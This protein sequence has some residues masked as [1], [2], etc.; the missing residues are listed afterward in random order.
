MSEQLNHMLFHARERLVA[1]A[2]AH[3]RAVVARHD[4]AAAAPSVEHL[5]Q[6]QEDLILALGTVV[7]LQS[8]ITDDQRQSIEALQA[9]IAQGRHRI[10]EL[11]TELQ[12]ERRRPWWRRRKHAQAVLRT[13]PAGAG[14]G[15]DTDDPRSS[16]VGSSPTLRSGSAAG[17]LDDNGRVAGGNSGR[18][19]SSSSTA[20][21][22]AGGSGAGGGAPSS[23]PGAFPAQ[24]AVEGS[25]SGEALGRETRGAVGRPRATSPGLSSSPGPRHPLGG[26]SA[27]DPGEDASSPTSADEPAVGETGADSGRGPASAGAD[28]DVDATPPGS[29]SARVPRTGEIVSFDGELW[30]IR[31]VDP[32]PSP[33]SPLMAFCQQSYGQGGKSARFLLDVLTFDYQVGVWRVEVPSP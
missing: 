12:A 20:E 13:S 11:T 30:L 16:D 28:R 24:S 19:S 23:E 6:G 4:G 32:Y 10:E 27:D 33:H 31:G 3:N 5:A 17:T 26:S 25:S 2:E 7:N 1:A 14:G 22:P 9:Q 15:D 18:G 29:V 21:T 8:L